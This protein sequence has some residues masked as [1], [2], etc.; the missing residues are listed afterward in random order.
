MSDDS[1]A[2]RVDRM[3]HASDSKRL[4]L[5]TLAAE[6]ERRDPEAY[7]EY[8]ANVAQNHPLLVWGDR[9]EMDAT[10]ASEYDDG[11]AEVIT[12]MTDS[13]TKL[14][15]AAVIC[16]L[17]DWPDGYA[18]IGYY[19]ASLEMVSSLTG[20]LYMIERPKTRSAYEVRLPLDQVTQEAI[21]TQRESDP[22]FAAAYAYKWLEH[23]GFQGDLIIMD[24]TLRET[25][26]LLSGSSVEYATC[27]VEREGA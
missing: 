20:A 19:P 18:G 23:F 24:E 9:T 25:I 21:Y 27:E 22:F 6:F 13:L 26:V 2:I 3:L 8:V 10:K 14:A 7:R 4:Q 16:G 12:E 5:M 11:R 1:G 15:P 17:T